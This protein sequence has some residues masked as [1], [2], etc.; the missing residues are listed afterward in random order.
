MAYVGVIGGLRRYPV[1][2]MLGEVLA[3]AAVTSQGVQGDR[4]Y[5]LYDP[6]ANKVVSV[7]RPG[8]WGRI[9]ELT[10]TTEAGK[11]GV[12][13][14]SGERITIDD[15]QLPTRL[16]EFFGRRVT[17]VSTPFEGA[18]FE[19]TWERELKDNAAPYFDMPSRDED[20]EETID[21]GGS[22]DVPGGL[23]NFGAIHIVTT[24]TVGA[25]TNAKPDSR[26]DAHRFRPN[27]VVDTVEDGFVETNWQDRTLAVGDVRLAVTFTVPRCVMTVQAQGDLPADRDILRTITRVNKVSHHGSAY[28]C[29]GVYANVPLEGTIRVGDRVVLE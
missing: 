19:E 24:G 7:K 29:V 5:A 16:S 22:W 26:F 1:K 27:I 28:P 12:T 20:G 11:V 14:P 10:A 2:S 21:N 23:F 9:F 6:E 8:R 3:Q 17:I 13:F 25:L 18:F 15:P 4:Q